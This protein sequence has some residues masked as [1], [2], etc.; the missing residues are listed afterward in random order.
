MSLIDGFGRPIT[1]LRLSVTDRCDFR[2]VYCMSEEMQFLPREKILSI[3]EMTFVARAFTELGVTKVRITGGEPLIRRNI[4]Q[5][6]S[7]LGALIGLEE[8]TL[9][10]NG[11]QLVKYAPL[12]VASG[13]KRINISLDSLQAEK[14]KQLT[15]TGKLDQVLGGIDAAINAGLQVKLNSVILKSRNSDEVL[16]LVKFAL[17]KKIDLSFIEEMPLGAISEHQRQQEFISSAELREIIQQE[18]VLSPSIN[19]PSTNSSSSKK[20]SKISSAGPSRYWQTPGHS[21]LIGFIS[22]H[23]DNF[24]GDCNRVRVTA[25]GKLLLCLGNEDSLDLRDIIRQ[26]PNDI[27]RL[28]QHIVAAMAHKPEKHHFDSA[29]QTD[30][31][32]FMNMTGG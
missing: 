14:F 15:R 32:R 3:E 22:P 28:K 1:Y 9:T 21:S 4:E 30:I 24:C 7:N 18:F 13:V 8:L 16:A 2:C 10:S 31:V 26:H 27:E 20:P 17:D 29:G 19:S 6:F 25:E 5:L 12:L 11:S 23:S